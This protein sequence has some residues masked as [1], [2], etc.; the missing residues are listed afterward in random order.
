[1]TRHC[2]ARTVRAV[3]TFESIASMT[4]IFEETLDPPTIAAN[5]LLGTSTAPR[6]Y[7]DRYRD[8]ERRVRGGGRDVEKK[9]R[10]RRCM[11]DSMRKKKKGE[12]KG[13]KEKKRGVRVRRD[14]EKRRVGKERKDNKQYGNLSGGLAQASTAW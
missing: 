3:R 9:G 8:G 7:R 4:E 1:M 12:A 10:L 13:E 6:R 14:K 2:H 5:G 11:Q